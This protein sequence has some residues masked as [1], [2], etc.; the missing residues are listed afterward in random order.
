MEDLTAK[1]GKIS[2][3]ATEG[4]AISI[5][6]LDPHSN[7]ANSECSIV[8]KICMD[9]HVSKDILASTMGSV[10]KISGNPSFM[11]LGQNIF[12]ITFNNIRDKQRILAGR[13]WSFDRN[14]FVLKEIDTTI[15]IGETAFDTEEFWVQIHNLPLMAM[16]EKVGQQIGSS[17]GELIEVDVNKDG[18]GWGL[19]LRVRVKIPL[20]TSLVRGKL[21]K[22][23]QK[24]FFLRFQYENLPRFCFKCGR[25]VH[26]PGNCP[27]SSE[28]RM[29]RNSNTDEYG[30]WLRAVPFNKRPK[31]QV[32]DK[33]PSANSMA[34]P[35]DDRSGSLEA[36]GQAKE[37]VDEERSG[38]FDKQFLP[39]GAVAGRLVVVQG[40]E[41]QVDGSQGETLVERELST[42]VHV[43]GVMKDYDMVS[44]KWKRKSR[45]TGVA[46][47][48]V[49]LSKRPAEIEDVADL[50]EA[51]V[52]SK[53]GRVE[54]VSV[55]LVSDV[56]AV[57]DVQP[58]PKL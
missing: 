15:P 10:W 47:P 2:L 3:T 17:L 13:P 46:S 39:E 14:L 38:S 58:C 33:L 11:D 21:L 24:E 19:Y 35:E 30:P 1:W 5:S 9:R 41:L 42:E 27:S 34:D 16:T 18:L 20:T 22:L 55:G 51:V 23:P 40:S 26:D 44:K 48:K 54:K 25:I 53:R 36:S 29:H 31:K 50:A 37:V 7:R 49:V 43:K 28:V 8:G 6:D 57:A 12:I 32:R 45:E 4:E 52:V 56:E